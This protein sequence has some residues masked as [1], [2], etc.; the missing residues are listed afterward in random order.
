[1]RILIGEFVN[2]MVWGGHIMP[3]EADSEVAA[4]PDRYNKSWPTSHGNCLDKN[5]GRDAK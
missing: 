2:I 1:M 4:T 3:F 5:V